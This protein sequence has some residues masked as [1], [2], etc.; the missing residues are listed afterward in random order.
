MRKTGYYRVRVG[1]GWLV[2]L[3]DGNQYL[4]ADGF[5]L[6]KRWIVLGSGN[7]YSD[8]D[9]DEIDEREILEVM[10]LSYRLPITKMSYN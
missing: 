10:G 4:V 5:Q 1:K 9:F 7:L 2:A 6:N 8:K 3:W